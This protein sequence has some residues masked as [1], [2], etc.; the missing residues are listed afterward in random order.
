MALVNFVRDVFEKLDV[1]RRV[2]KIRKEHRI[3]DGDGDPL[4]AHLLQSIERSADADYRLWIEQLGATISIR[5]QQFGRK[6]DG[7]RRDW[8]VQRVIE[9]GERGVE[10]VVER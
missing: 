7:R 9:C 10:L 6:G 8:R 4:H 5:G 2:R 3:F 1:L